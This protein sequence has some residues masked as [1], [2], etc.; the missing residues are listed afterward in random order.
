MCEQ[1]GGFNIQQI[2]ILAEVISISGADINSEVGDHHVNSRVWCD[3]NC[4][5]INSAECNQEDVGT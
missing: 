3:D 4:R 2:Q 5:T 1:R